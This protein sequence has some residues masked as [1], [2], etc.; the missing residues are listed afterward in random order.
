MI[1]L[2]TLSVAAIGMLSLTSCETLNADKGPEPPRER[3]SSMPHNMPAS[4]EGSAGL[5]GLAGGGVN[6]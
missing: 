1:K 4:W 5:P 3:L 2:L 6:Y